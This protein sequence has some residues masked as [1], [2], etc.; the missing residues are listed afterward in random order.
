MSVAVREAGPGDEARLDAFARAHGEPFHL[1]AWAHATRDALGHEEVRLFTE[2]AGAVT[3]LLPLT[4]R[5]SPLFGRALISV[6][7]AVGGGVVATTEGARAALLSAAREAGRARRADFVE[8]RG[9]AIPEDWAL[10]Q[11]TYAGFGLDILEDEDAQLLA[12]PRKKRADVRKG[13]EAL[14]SGALTASVTRDT[15]GFWRAYAA[16]QRDHGTPVL[17]RRLLRSLMD[18]LGEA[19]RVCEVRAAGTLLAA[20]FAFSH[21][22]T[23]YLYH[24]AISPEAKRLRAGDA[25]YWWM[26]RRAAEEGLAR[27]DFGRSKTNSGPYAYKTYW[28]MEPRPL[29]YAYAMLSGGDVP[30]VNP[31]NPKFAAVTAAWKRLPLPVANRIGPVLYGHLG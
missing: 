17:P 24:A 30:D 23:L 4:D 20:V 29:T 19:C 25:M 16:A 5:R 14:R 3:G 26:I 2:E 12:I 8:L 13:I 9:G 10:K 27:I 15:D 31:N 1:S 6:G 28:G 22:D 18:G 11:G 7:F 21:R